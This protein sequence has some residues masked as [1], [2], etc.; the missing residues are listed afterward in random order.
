MKYCSIASLPHRG[1]G[2]VFMSFMIKKSLERWGNEGSG[3][4][5]RGLS[6]WP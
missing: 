4:D 1:G 6:I 2:K 3:E 5:M